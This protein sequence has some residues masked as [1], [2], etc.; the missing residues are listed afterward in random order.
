MKAIVIAGDRRPTLWVDALRPGRMH[1][2][3]AA[4]N[5]G[6]G[7]NFQHFPGV[8][9]LLDDGCLGLRRDHPGQ[10]VTPPRMG[11]KISPPESPKPA[12]D[13]STG[14]PRNASPSNTLWPTASAGNN[15]R[16]THRRETLPAT[17]WAVVSLVSDRAATAC[18]RPRSGDTHLT[19]Y[20][21]PARKS[22]G[23]A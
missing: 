2:A 20:H 19:R 21:A 7:V 16:W 14:T 1:D 18:S 17:Y 9:V 11:S 23:K 3:T 13:R 10:A 5:E 12:G 8:E 6:I 22:L 15:C 4:C